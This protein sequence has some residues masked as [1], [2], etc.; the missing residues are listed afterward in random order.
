MD[1]ELARRNMIDSQIRPWEVLDTTVLAAFAAV[2]RDH[3]V[4]ESYQD[5][6]YADFPIPLGN[7]ESMM[8]PRVEGRMLQALAPKPTDRALEIGT[9][10]GFVAALLGHLTQHTVSIDIHEPFVQSARE[11]MRGTY[12]NVELRVADGAS[13]YLVDGPYD[14]V[15][16]TG[17]LND[18][19]P[20]LLDMLA[21]G[22]RMFIV[23]GVPP[24]MTATLFTKLS[25]RNWSQQALFETELK[26]LLNAPRR[27][28][29]QF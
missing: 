9:G 24:A 18:F 14:V 26:P 11:R 2:P 17:A 20:R 12:D 27:D 6:A 4:P 8:T 28:A 10:S 25:D 16:I 7:G 5:L 13:G 19:D 29:F 15:A 21:L 3:F 22:G 1:T 23:L